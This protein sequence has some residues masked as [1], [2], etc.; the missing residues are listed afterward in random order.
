[1][2]EKNNH[3]VSKSKINIEPDI[4]EI[5]HH[6]QKLFV[7]S[8][9]IFRVSSS[10]EG[11]DYG[12]LSDAIALNLDHPY[13]SYRLPPAP[14][15]TTLNTTSAAN[16]DSENY[17][18]WVTYRLRQDEAIFFIGKTPPPV[19]YFSYRS[20]LFWRFFPKE[21]Q[22][23]GIFA[24]LGDTINNMR[25][26]VDRN[27]GGVFER[28]VVII[29]TANNDTYKKVCEILKATGV[30]EKIIN[31]DKIPIE[32]VNMGLENH[33]DQFLFVN[34]VGSFEDKDKGGAY[35]LNENNS[36]G[37]VFRL[38]PKQGIPRC[39]IERAT[40][41]TPRGSGDNNEMH[42]M[43][44]LDTLRQSILDKYSHLK[45][46]ELETRV[47]IY[48][49]Y[50]AIQRGVDAVG[51]DRDTTY[52]C[53]EPFELRNLRDEFVIIYG[54]NHS[55]TNKATYCNF[56]VYGKEVLNGVCGKSSSDPDFEG[57]VRKFLDDYPELV[58]HFYVWKVGRFPPDDESRHYIQVPYQIPELRE[59]HIFRNS[60]AIPLDKEALIGFRAYLDPSTGVGPAWW[61]LLYDRAIKFSPN[62]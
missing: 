45:A 21:S 54:V 19:D 39:A 23:R 35:V 50:D 31:F 15:Q 20:Y 14:G 46:K 16:A 1:M 4:D 38:T 22:F 42:L 29:T 6:L 56:T 60:A 58:G 33:H 12:I 47:W 36:S 3:N 48:D 27:D 57:G 2:S 9:G 5:V 10:A 11:Y 40:N 34:R 8:E 44:H 41:L 53:T 32:I 62:I 25:I 61:E 37:R 18:Y 43:P 28:P 30:R 49:G 26:N 52:L 24:S 7:V 59:K 13:L 51:E 55:K 17:G